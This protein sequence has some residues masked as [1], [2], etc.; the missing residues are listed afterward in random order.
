[1]SKKLLFALW[2]GLFIL[3]AGLGFI[4]GFSQNVSAGAQA[5]LTVLAV[6]FFAPSAC[7]IYGAKKEKDARTLKLVRGISL[8]SLGLTL[9]ALVLNVLSAMG[10]VTMGNVLFVVSSP[11][12][13]SG[14]WA[15]SL[16]LWACLLIVSH[17][18]LRKNFN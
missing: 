1:M 14:Y 11:M 3:C 12:V 18:L 10:T 15:L 13:C 4:P 7:L 9:L 5:V 16:F 17:S 8:L 2:G 6:A